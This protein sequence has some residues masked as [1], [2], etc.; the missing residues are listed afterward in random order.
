MTDMESLNFVLPIAISVPGADGK[1][2]RPDP[3]LADILDA[4]SHVTKTGIKDI[5]SPRR[6][7]PFVRARHIYFWIAHKHTC[8]GFP[9]IG[10]H[11]GDRDH[12]TAMH[13]VNK[14]SKDYSVYMDDIEKVC[15]ILEI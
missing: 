8:H 13:G 1:F 5:R 2:S 11:C 7:V 12:S 3:K 15:E 14:V 4:V 10:K 9:T 6:Y